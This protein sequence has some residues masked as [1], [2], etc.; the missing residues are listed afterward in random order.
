MAKKEFNFGENEF[1]YINGEELE[2]WQSPKYRESK[3]KAIEMIEKGNYGLKESDFWILK[4]TTKNGKMAYTGLIISHNGCLKINE[5][6]ENKVKPNCFSL[7]K[8]GYNGSLV[9]VYTDEDTYEVGEISPDN[10][11]ALEK[12]QS[13]YPYAMAFKRCFDRVVLKKSKLAFSGIYS[14][15]EADEFKAN[16]AEETEKEIEDFKNHTLYED[17]LLKLIEENKLD[18]DKVC[19]LCNVED[20]HKMSTK[21][22]KY[23]IDNFE[24]LKKKVS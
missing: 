4:N 21:N 13:G 17:A 24:E 3:D 9:Y 23:S 2:V 11:K 10:Y 16:Q 7:D 22:L 8:D 12:K 15:V 19:K 5:A 20:I 18:Y 1:E 6:L 14:E